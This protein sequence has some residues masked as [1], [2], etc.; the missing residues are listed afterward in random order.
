MKYQ[1][2]N[3]LVFLVASLSVV[4]VVMISSA[5]TDDP[6]IQIS[7][8]PAQAQPSP[9]VKLAEQVYKNIQI[10]KGVPASELEPTM[11][12]ISGSLGVKCN[13]CHV[14]SFDKDERPTKQTARRMIL[15]VLDLNKEN[16]S[17]EKTVTCYTCHQGQPRPK[18]VPLV[19]ANLWQ[20]ATTAAEPVL[21]TA[22]EI[23]ERHVKAIGGVAALQNIKTRVAKGSR[24]GADGILVPEEVYQKAPNKFSTVTTYPNETFSTGFNGVAGWGAS[25]KGGVRSLPDA[26]LAQVKSDAEF[27]KE[28]KAKELYSK[29]TV[30]GRQKIGDREVFVVEA[31]PLTGPREKLYFDVESGLLLR[32][33]T[34]SE[35][36]LGMFPMQIDY[37]DYRVV[38]GI[39][40]PFLIRWSMPGRSWGRKISEIKQNVD[41][42]NQVFEP[43]S[44]SR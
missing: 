3:I 11:A 33:Y 13:Y 2:R 20:P 16:F 35:T 12:F 1:S 43:P 31:T 36:L 34:E 30:A 40:L 22:D 4:S 23:F 9:Q 19:G 6:G 32:K 17:G 44:P 8:L 27:Y 18:S 41:I 24:I 15:M 42:A 39:K 10:F 25:S 37:E 5:N 14:N 7:P 29:L 38:D 21:P 28:I 26:L